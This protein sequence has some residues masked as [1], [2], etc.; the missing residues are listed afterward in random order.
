METRW[1]VPVLTQIILILMEYINFKPRFY[2]RS[3]VALALAMY[4]AGLS[5]WRAILPHSTLLYDYRKFSNVKYVVP[6]SGKYAVDETKVLTVRGEYYY[7]WVVRDVVT[8]GIPFFMVTSLRSGLHVLIILV[9]M[10]E[11]EELA[12]RYFKRVDQVVYLHD[13]ASI[14]NAFNWY[15]VNHEKVTFEER[16]YAEQGFRTTKHRISSMD[17]HFPWNSNRF[18]ITRWLSTFFLIY[19]LLYTPVY[20][21]DRG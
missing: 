8:R 13:G 20:L 7:V 10:R 9:K 5:S 1:K 12:S 14:Y 4:L 18:T 17:K 21:L 16:D 3:E 15:N 6:L 2:A 11:V 19:N